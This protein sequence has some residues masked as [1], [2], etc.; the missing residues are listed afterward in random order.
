MQLKSK[1][2]EDEDANISDLEE[3]EVGLNHGMISQAPQQ[4]EFKKNEAPAD[5]F[6][7]RNNSASTHFTEENGIEGM[8][9]NSLMSFGSGQLMGSIG[10]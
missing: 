10:P 1:D 9:Q 2:M 4:Q 8:K 6:I 3:E 7:V 5:F